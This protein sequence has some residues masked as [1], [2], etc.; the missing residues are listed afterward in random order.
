MDSPITPIYQDFD[1]N[2]GFHPVRKDLVLVRDEQAVIASIR[3]LL[4]MNHFDLRFRPEVGSN[5]RRLL[6]ENITP[7]TADDLRRFIRETIE[8][9]E[10]RARIAVLQVKAKPDENGYAVYLECYIGVNPKAA[11][12]NLLLERIR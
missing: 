8:N 12:V 10:P 2:F 6:F 7:F 9:F 3:N 1:L 5:I 4:M 11:V